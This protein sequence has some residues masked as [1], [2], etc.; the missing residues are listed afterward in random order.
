MRRLLV[1]TAD[2]LGLTPGINAAVRRAHV[3][4]VVTATSVLAVGRAF[5]GAARLAREQPDLELGAHLALVGEDPPLLPPGRIPSL[6]DAD[7]RFPLSYRAVVGRG[8]ARRLDPAD[9]RRELGAQLEQVRGIGVPVTHVDTHQHTH[10]WP[11]VARVVVDLAREFGIPVVRLPRSRARGVVG[12]GV[13]VLA[14]GLGRRLRRAGLRTTADYAGLDEAGHLDAARFAGALAAAARRGA[15]TLE[16]N[17]H[18]GT[19]GE[20]G[21]ARFRWDDYQWGDELAM[22]VDPATRDLVHRH[23]YALAGFRDLERTTP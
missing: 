10:L 20:P 9:L 17:S 2:D 21:L 11:G 22:L 8:L 18:P 16:I 4:G 19:P 23:G 7:G 14:L 3:E 5:D 1:V 12:A 15:P 6:V 13:G